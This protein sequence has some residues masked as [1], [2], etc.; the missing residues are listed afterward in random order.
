MKRSRG[1]WAVL[2]ILAG[3]CLWA[4][5]A[6]AGNNSRVGWDPVSEFGWEAD[7]KN[8][9]RF[10]TTTVSANTA[11][12]LV[13]THTAGNFVVPSAVSMAP[14]Q[15]S[16]TTVTF[17]GRAYMVF[18]VVSSTVNVSVDFDTVSLST[19][20]SPYLTQG[21]WWS[22][23]DPV[24]WQGQVCLQAPGLFTVT[25]WYWGLRPR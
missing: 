10:T 25:G 22:P 5:P 6:V 1:K 23:D 13:S 19:T 8:V 14:V 20:T 3:L 9:V 18:Q 24:A 16:S 2:T 12:C 4:L 7:A 17:G 15:T 11:V 21:Q